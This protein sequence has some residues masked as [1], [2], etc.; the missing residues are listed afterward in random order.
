MQ[1]E[2]LPGRQ[3][4]DW[5]KFYLHALGRTAQDSGG[6]RC[7]GRALEQRGVKQVVRSLPLWLNPLWLNSQETSTSPPGKIRT[8]SGGSVRQTKVSVSIPASHL[9]WQRDSSACPWELRLLLDPFASFFCF[10]YCF[11]C[12]SSPSLHLCLSLALFLSLCPSVH[13]LAP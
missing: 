12:F 1:S 3:T 10:S 5:T 9:N 7:V 8:A 6:D 4:R 11:L 13:L 2:R